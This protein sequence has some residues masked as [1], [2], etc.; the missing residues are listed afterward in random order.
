[1]LLTAGKLGCDTEQPFTV[2]QGLNGAVYTI[3]CDTVAA[4][5][6]YMESGN[7]AN[8]TRADLALFSDFVLYEEGTLNR[9]DVAAL[10]VLLAGIV[11]SGSSCIKIQG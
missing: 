2:T 8:M 7:S 5:D 3:D 10:D 6:R 11:T 9:G 4:L 1:M